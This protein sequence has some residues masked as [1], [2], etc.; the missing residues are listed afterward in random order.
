[1]EFLAWL[2]H[3]IF[4]KKESADSI[5]PE[6]VSTDGKEKVFDNYKDLENYEKEAAFKNGK[7][8][9]DTGS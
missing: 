3:Q 5:P 2:I 8:E 9:Q 6:Y 7:Y 1:M 4:G